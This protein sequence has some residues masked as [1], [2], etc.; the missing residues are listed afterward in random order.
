[1]FPKVMQPCRVAM[2][3]ITDSCY[4]VYDTEAWNLK[5][6]YRNTA[7]ILLGWGMVNAGIIRLFYQLCISKPEP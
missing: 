2:A 6:T 5:T 4:E 3:T 7:Y 1:M